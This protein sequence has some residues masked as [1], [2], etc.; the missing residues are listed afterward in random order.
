MPGPFRVTTQEVLICGSG[1]R[2]E[3]QQAKLAR[4]IA[5]F[6]CL[7]GGPR[8]YPSLGC[9][10]P[11]LKSDESPCGHCETMTKTIGLSSLVAG[12]R[13]LLLAWDTVVGVRSPMLSLTWQTCHN[14]WTLRAKPLTPQFSGDLLESP[15]PAAVILFIQLDI[16]PTRR[17]P[18]FILI[19][20]KEQQ[21]DLASGCLG[22][23]AERETVSILSGNRI[24]P[25]AA[26]PLREA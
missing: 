7:F 6:G 19:N 5:R 16:D 9:G 10:Q 11:Q 17:V 1:N 15:G 24:N 8:R 23:L 25:N 13:E 2:S 14:C 26:N 21:T 22:R 20:A 12:F 4:H 18:M 3:L